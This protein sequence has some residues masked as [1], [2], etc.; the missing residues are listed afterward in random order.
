MQMEK[1]IRDP[2]GLDAWKT[3]LM[4]VRM[5]GRRVLALG[6]GLNTPC[7]YAARRGALSVLGVDPSPWR[8]QRARFGAHRAN[9]KYLCLPL[10][11]LQL[12]EKSFDLVLASLDSCAKGDPAGLLERVHG[13][14]D[15][16]GE[17]LLRVDRPGEAD[18][19]SLRDHAAMYINRLLLCGFEI[20]LLEETE[21]FAWLLA[22]NAATA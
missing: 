17:L 12:P 9:L 20:R 5:D 21:N 14:L 16:S 7:N 18:D 22:K 6:D 8:V 1:T 13:W 3:C 11:E 2:F 15:E 4:P 19:D 10:E